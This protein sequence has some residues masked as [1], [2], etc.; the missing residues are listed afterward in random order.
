MSLPPA[1][2]WP[3]FTETAAK[4][5]AYDRGEC[6]GIEV[7]EA[8]F[9]ATSDRNDWETVSLVGLGPPKSVSRTGR[10][11]RIFDSEMWPSSKAFLRVGDD[12]RRRARTTRSKAVPG[13]RS[14]ITRQKSPKLR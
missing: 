11:A 9:L 10:S 4:L 3:D 2:D 1:D 13:G 12:S 14:R 6:Q 7:R 5:A 8:F